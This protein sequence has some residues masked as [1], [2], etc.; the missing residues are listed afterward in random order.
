MKTL[1]LTLFSAIS[2]CSYSQ[3]LM[4]IGEVFDFNIGDKFHY[5]IPPESVPPAI[6]RI[7]IIGKFYSTSE[8]TVFYVRYHD[9]YW[10][11]VD[12][13]TFPPQLLYHFYTET[14]TVNYTDLDSL[15]SFYDTGF[16]CDTMYF[17]CDTSLYNSTEYCDRLINGYYVAVNEFEPEI[18][19]KE[20]GK[21]IGWVWNYYYSSSSLPPGVQW[22]SE[23]F[24]YQEDGIDCGTPDTMMVSTPELDSGGTLISIYPNP[25]NDFIYLSLPDKIG[26]ATFILTDLSGRE[27]LRESLNSPSA[28]K[29]QVSS[30][31][32]GVYLGIIETFLGRKVVKLIIK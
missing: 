22:D 23:L 2:L 25:A 4:T 10:T 12:W 5:R 18:Y 16:Q 1:I 19:Q 9:S 32:S 24:Y 3:D 7:T 31:H 27:I 6:D 30:Y 29:F 28:D 14:D 11:E 15:I 17:E 21:G 8:D 20:Y 13:D 26:V